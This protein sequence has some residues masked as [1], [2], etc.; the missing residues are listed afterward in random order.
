MRN[1][2]Y[3]APLPE[4]VMSSVPWASYFSALPGSAPIIQPL[5]DVDSRLISTTWRAYLAQQAN[6]PLRAVVVGLDGMVNKTWLTYF[7]SLH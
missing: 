2:P 4:L 1:V 6:P 7:Q 3:L 5:Y